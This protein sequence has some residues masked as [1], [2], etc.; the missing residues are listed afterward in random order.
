MPERLSRAVE[1]LNAA[2]ALLLTLTALFWAGNAIAGQLAVGEI[3]PFTLTFLRW[4]LVSVVLW[5][6]YGGEVVAAWPQVRPRMPRIVVMASLGFTIFNALFYV[7]SHRTTAVNIGILQGSIP[8]FVLIG[9][10]VFH[11]TR[12]GALQGVGVL[13]TIAGVVLVA[14]RGAP[15]DLLALG[16]NP[17]DALMLLA[18]ALYSGYTVML[19]SRPAIPGR[20]FFTLMTPI[21]AATALPLAAVEALSAGFEPPTLQGWLVTLYVAVFPSCLSQLFFMRGV[22]LIGPGRAGVFVNLVP[23]FAA[24]LAVAL[25]GQEFAWF[26]GL[27]LVLVIG[28]IWLA[29]RGADPSAMPAVRRSS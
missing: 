11:G 19:R 12:V 27:A 25:L 5:I 7:A 8:V 9:A 4:I 28:G 17:G 26:H 22:D 29:Q 1:R 13:A 15:G 20:A 16:V 24:L 3:G 2:P 21:A 6:L 10:F 18:C 23:V 14:T